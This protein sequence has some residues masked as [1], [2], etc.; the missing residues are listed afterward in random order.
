MIRGPHHRLRC[1]AVRPP[2]RFLFYSFFLLFKEPKKKKPTA[3]KKTRRSKKNGDRLKSPERRDF[4]CFFFTLLFFLPFWKPKK[5]MHS[6]FFREAPQLDKH[7]TAWPRSQWKAKKV[8][9][10]VK[11]TKQK[12]NQ[13]KT[14]PRIGVLL[15]MLPESPKLRKQSSDILQETKRYLA[16][17]K[18]KKGTPSTAASSMITLRSWRYQNGFRGSIQV[19][20]HFLSRFC[21]RIQS[22]DRDAITSLLWALI[23]VAI[24]SANEFS[25][26][27]PNF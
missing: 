22:N 26:P 5:K 18:K 1:A 4:F 11:K 15:E 20:A 7:S 13:I 25:V 8:D 10:L 24:H 19:D 2:S 16:E 23:W 12:K 17:E 27:I 9:V 6:P 14:R 3:R 21:H